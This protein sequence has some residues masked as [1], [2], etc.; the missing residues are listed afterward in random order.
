MTSPISAATAGSMLIHTPNTRIGIRRSDSSSSRYGMT[1]EST[2]IATPIAST[3]GRNIALPPA[4]TAGGVTSTAATTM[5]M[6]KPDE[7]G[8][9]RPVAELSTM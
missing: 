4:I 6:A 3:A 5:A 2:P 7:P 1:E 8:K 9:R